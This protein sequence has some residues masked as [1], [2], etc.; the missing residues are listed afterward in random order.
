MYP[1]ISKMDG[2]HE[3]KTLYRIDEFGGVFLFL[4]T[5]TWAYIYLHEK[6]GKQNSGL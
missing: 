6:I 3:G 1:K 5:P 4:E 2:E